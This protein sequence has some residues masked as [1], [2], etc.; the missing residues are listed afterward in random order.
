LLIRSPTRHSREPEQAAAEQGTSQTP[1]LA[2]C[3][4]LALLE[5]VVRAAKL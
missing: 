4:A 3:V 2:S 5:E 1:L